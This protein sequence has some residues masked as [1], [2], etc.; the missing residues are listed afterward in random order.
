MLAKI[1]Q[2]HLNRWQDT[3]TLASFKGVIFRLFFSF[4]YIIFLF[5]VAFGIIIGVISWSF[6][7]FE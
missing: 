1:K 2:W 4:Y 6:S 7:Q 3:V 5:M